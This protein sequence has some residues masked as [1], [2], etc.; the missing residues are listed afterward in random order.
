MRKNSNALWAL[1][2]GFLAISYAMFFGAGFESRSPTGLYPSITSSAIIK[3]VYDGD[4]ITVTFYK[5]VKIRM[6]DCWASELRSSDPEEKQKAIE[7]R[8]FL[9]NVLK[10]GDKVLIKIPTTDR[11]QDS[12]TFGRALGY[13]WKDLDGD[14]NLDNI[15]DYMVKNGH[16]TK[17]KE[18]R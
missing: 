4:T 13:V 7:A 10:N 5:E 12:L 16:A 2:G 3:D 18:K 11:L 1:L 9:K 15:S 6:L 8:E 14:G 17:N